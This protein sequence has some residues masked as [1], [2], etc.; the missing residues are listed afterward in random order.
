MNT[1][2]LQSAYQTGYMTRNYSAIAENRATH[3]CNIQYN[4]AMCG[5]YPLQH[6]P[7]HICYCAEFNRSTSKG[8]GINI[9][10]L[11]IFGSAWAPPT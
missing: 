4:Y 5:V 2:Q 10:E 8:V 6:A 3:L 1:M 9:E 7:P 11:R